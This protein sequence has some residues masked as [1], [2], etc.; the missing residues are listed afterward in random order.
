MAASGF[1]NWKLEVESWKLKEM[2]SYDFVEGWLGFGQWKLEV[3]Y[4]K[5]EVLFEQQNVM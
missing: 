4:W 2:S 3:R 5:L 1:I